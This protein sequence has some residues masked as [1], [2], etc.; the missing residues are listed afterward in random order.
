LLAINLREKWTLKVTNMKRGFK[1]QCER[2]AVEIRRTLGIGPDQP[3]DALAL[4]RSL[5]VTVWK[6][7]DIKGLALEDLHQLH[8]VDPETW[9]ALTLRSGTR[10]LV[11]YNS[12]HSPAR[13]NSM[14]M[15]ELSHI[16]LGHE[17]ISTQVTEDGYLVPVAYD[18]DQED[19]ANWLAG[20]LL[21]PRPA[22]LT[23]R[24][25]A[26]GDREAQ[27]YFRV[28]AD[29]LTWRIRMTGVDY[30]LVR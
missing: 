27:S 16:M 17:L 1:S 6:D 26:M 25:S 18:Q 5:G 4:A 20:T 12:A 28:S 8:V 11:V 24:R 2:R 3:L 10:F 15:H 21:L 22:L 19:E 23:L 9:L 30:Q 7:T 14:I 13:C 29:M